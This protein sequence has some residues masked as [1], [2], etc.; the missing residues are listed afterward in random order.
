MPRPNGV[1]VIAGICFVIAGYF[2]ISGVIVLFRPSSASMLP[3]GDLKRALVL[4]GPY[5]ALLA[6]AVWALIGWGLLRLHNWARW[7]AMLLAAWGIA[8]VLAA[9]AVGSGRHGWLLVCQGLEIIARLAIVWYLFR[10]PMADRFTKSAK[11]M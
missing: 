8:A 5:L 6:G 7:A 9:T 11:T 10:M 2:F 1:S 3:S 4:G